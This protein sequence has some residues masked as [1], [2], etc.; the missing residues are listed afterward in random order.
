[1]RRESVAEILDKPTTPLK[2]AGGAGTPA[3]IVEIPENVTVVE[4]RIQKYFIY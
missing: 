1:M 3:R 4:S 2:P